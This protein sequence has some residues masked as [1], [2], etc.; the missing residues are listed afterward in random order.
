MGLSSL[1]NMSLHILKALDL[2]NSNGAYVTNVVSGGP[3]DKAGVLAGSQATSIQGLNK[4]GDWIVA[5]DGQPVKSFGDFLNYLIMTKQP[6]ETA[7]ITVMR[8]GEK[9]DLQV[10]LEKRP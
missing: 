7:T 10:T 9:V 3:A 1:D 2:E 8:G 5:I 4:G 6:G